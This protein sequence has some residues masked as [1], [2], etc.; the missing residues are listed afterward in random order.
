MNLAATLASLAA[1][2]QMLNQMRT[3]RI[4]RNAAMDAAPVLPTAAPMIGAGGPSVPQAR[5]AY[6]AAIDNAA[7]DPAAFATARQALQQAYRNEAF[8]RAPAY[9]P[10]RVAPLSPEQLAELSKASQRIDGSGPYAGGL[11]VGGGDM[12]IDPRWANLIAAQAAE[13]AK[14]IRGGGNYRTD[15]TEQATAMDATRRM[16]AQIRANPEAFANTPTA[17]PQAVAN[18]TNAARIAGLTRKANLGIIPAETIQ[19]LFA[20]TL[21]AGPNGAPSPAQWAALPA[22]VTNAMA[23]QANVGRQIEAKVKEAEDALRIQTQQHEERMKAAEQRHAQQMEQMRQQN[24][25]LT[26]QIEQAKAQLAEQARQFDAGA[27]GRDADV[28]M[29]KAQTRT[30]DAQAKA[31]EAQALSLETQAKQQAQNPVQLAQQQLLANR[32]ELG[33]EPAMAFE[34]YRQKA[35]SVPSDYF[36]G[37]RPS[38]DTAPQQMKD[39]MRHVYDSGKW[40]RTFLGTDEG[41]FQDYIVSQLSGIGGANQK[42][43]SLIAEQFYESVN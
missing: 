13:A 30:A 28:G 14:E 12:S 26:A 34:S 6:F 17:D 1:G 15:P 33:M 18:V 40:P 24:A 3:E 27:A 8:A 39:F 21:P 5:A 38:L 43:I 2:E 32:P 9:T 31:A 16:E 25:Q 41:D 20:A 19:P 10:S 35:M 11:R 37:K 7:A 23:T 22:E 36:N 4:A 29:K 42:A